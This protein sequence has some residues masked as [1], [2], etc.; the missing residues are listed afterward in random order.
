MSF[1]Q[2][3][4]RLI[5]GMVLLFLSL[6][7]IV[8]WRVY[9][10]A[11]ERDE[12]ARVQVQTFVKAIE[13]HVHHTV[14]YVDLSVQGLSNALKLLPPEQLQSGDTIRRLIA[15]QSGTV[16]SDFWLVAID[17][18]GMGI[19]ASAQDIPVQGVSYADR[20]FFQVH[21]AAGADVG[22]FVGQPLEG[23]V[24][25][26]RFFTLSRRVEDRN[27][28][29][30]GIVTAPIDARVFASFFS[31]SRFNENVSISLI[32]RNGKVIA[33]SPDFEKSFGEDISA[34][35]LFR[36]LKDA[37]SG[38]YEGASIFDGEKRRIAYSTVQDLPLVVT[39]GIST[40][41]LDKAYRKDQ[42]V[43]AAGLALIAAI[44]FSSG[45]AVLAAH[46]SMAR[47]ETRYRQ[48]Y[49]SIRDGIG[50]TDMDGRIV[51]CNDEFVRLLGYSREELLG[52]SFT[53]VTPEKWH[54]PENRI[55][56]DQVMTRGFSDEYEKEYIRK[57]GETIS[58]SLKTW[59]IRNEV[60][61]PVMMGA[62]VRDIT[63]RKQAEEVVREK[64]AYLR[65]IYDTS[66]VAIFDVNTAG[67]ITHA[68][69]RM[70]EMFA[71][72]M[73]TLIG[74][75]YVDHL[76]P[77]ERDVGRKKMLALLA[78]D[79]PS[80]DLDRHYWRDDGTEFWGHLTGRRMLDAAGRATGLIGI[81]ADI[82]DRVHAE[83]EIRE[84]NATL[85]QRVQERTQALEQS[86]KDLET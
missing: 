78:S 50:I 10:A 47:S 8:A 41:A 28:R 39:V 67:I 40:D 6:A 19:A 74:S 83:Q 79:I 84:L 55:L 1:T 76:H 64:E 25:K 82:T 16:S 38:T 80:V 36:H 65:L 57:N 75:E 27:G 33:R 56:A 43:A 11:T 71:C 9:D 52:M 18:R 4:G 26:R 37:P 5:G 51:D 61:T 42:L 17:S 34:S 32:H 46:A 14:K 53:K 29:F 44:L 30:F 7:A 81:I 48:L 49:T 20:D 86:V 60:G 35:N 2:F 63:G 24:T 77:S 54:A 58:V 59:V 22:L 31:D 72:P 68:N 45:Y 13:A 66:S 15:N 62:I 3:R 69:R 12:A 70:V 23:K 73:E 85:E 21:T